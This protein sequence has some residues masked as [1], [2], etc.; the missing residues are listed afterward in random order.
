MLSLDHD[1][2]SLGGEVVLQPLRHLDG[3]AFLHL[4]VAGEQLDNAGQLG[5]AEN[6]FAR[7]VANVGDP[8]NGSMWCSHRD[9]TG[10]LLA[11]TSS[12]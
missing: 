1:T 12:S 4:E 8:V 11:R 9:C 7:Q 6:P 10:M 3:Q 5:Q 2:D